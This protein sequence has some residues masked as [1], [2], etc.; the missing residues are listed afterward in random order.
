MFIKQGS[1]QRYLVIIWVLKNQNQKYVCFANISK[2]Y[3][4]SNLALCKTLAWYDAGK[5]S[6]MR[7]QDHA[8]K[9]TFFQIHFKVQSLLAF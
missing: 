7:E 6:S 4:V 1:L 2:T 3:D 9:D 5:K 8:L